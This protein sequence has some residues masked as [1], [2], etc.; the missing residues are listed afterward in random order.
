M[1]LLYRKAKMLEIKAAK[2][3]PLNYQFGGV[4]VPY[5]DRSTKI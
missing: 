5:T 3:S 1:E 4:G 2:D